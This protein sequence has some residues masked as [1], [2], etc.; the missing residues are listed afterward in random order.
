VKPTLKAAITAL[1]PPRTIT[2]GGNTAP[3][4]NWLGNC[5]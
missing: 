5:V 3:M 2:V 4:K 1:S